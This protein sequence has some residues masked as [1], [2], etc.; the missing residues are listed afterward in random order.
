[1]HDRLIEGELRCGALVEYLKKRSLPTIVALSEDATRING[2]VQYDP[3]SN[4]I[5]GFV[6]P[7]DD[8]NGMPIP[9][10]FPAR[11]CDEMIK[12]FSSSNSVANFV[13]VVMAKPFANVRPFCLL[14]FC[15]HS[16]FTAE[17]VVKRWKY[18]AAE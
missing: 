18:I 15:S 6:L 5:I 7:T 3:V 13:N 1:M 4:E 16:K 17:S 8:E 10:S 2:P 9:H 11:S 14:L 12:H